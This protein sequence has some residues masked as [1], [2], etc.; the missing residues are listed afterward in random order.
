MVAYFYNRFLLELILE[1]VKKFYFLSESLLEVLLNIRMCLFGII[2]A[3]NHFFHLKKSV[4]VYLNNFIKIIRISKKYVFYFFSYIWNLSFKI[5]FF[6]I[7]NKCTLNHFTSK[8]ILIRSVPIKSTPLFHMQFVFTLNSSRV[9]QLYGNNLWY[10]LTLLMH[11]GILIEINL[12]LCPQENW[13]DLLSG[14]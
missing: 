9:Y 3:K 11:C 4:F 1:E 13:N 10:R 6:K 12:V 7:L 14:E 8:S 2:L 5:T